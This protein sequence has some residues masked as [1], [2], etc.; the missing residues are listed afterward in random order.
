MHIGP[1][2]SLWVQPKGELAPSPYTPENK[3]NNTKLVSVKHDV[4][5]YSPQ[6][7]S[8]NT[9]RPLFFKDIFNILKRLRLD[10]HLAHSSPNVL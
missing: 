6:V 9:G 4:S 8:L 1:R 5:S 3:I 7:G 2:C 10:G